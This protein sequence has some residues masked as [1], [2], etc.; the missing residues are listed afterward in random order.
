[1][2]RIIGVLV[3]LLVLTT[4]GWALDQAAL[5]KSLDGLSAGISHT[6][7]GMSERQGTAERATAGS[8]DEQTERAAA[9]IKQM[10]GAIENREDLAAA[11][12]MVQSFAGK[13]EAN[14]LAARDANRWLK[15]RATFLNVSIGTTDGATKPVAEPERKRPARKQQMAPVDL[16][17]NE[18]RALL[19]VTVPVAEAV[20]SFEDKD[21]ERLALLKEILNRHEARLYANFTDKSYKPVQTNCYVSGKKFV[22]ESLMRTYKGVIVNND[23]NAIVTLNAGG[24][25]SPK[26]IDVTLKPKRDTTEQ[27]TLDWYRTVVEKDP[28]GYMLKN[29]VADIMSLGKVENLAGEQKLRIK[30][31]KAELWIVPNGGDRRSAVYYNKV[32]FGDIYLPIR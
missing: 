18:Q 32:D 12:R 14:R 27:G 4:P 19:M 7:Y 2:Q 23:F 8:F 5:E 1:M 31:A 30:N 21:D 20:L 6:A 10:I 29:K 24:F 25:F 26:T 22:L 28:F 11:A 16:L 13:S 9:S 17:T 15:E 3:L